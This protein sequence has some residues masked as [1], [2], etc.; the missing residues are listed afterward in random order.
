MANPG[1]IGTP[2][3]SS[4]ADDGE[5]TVAVARH[6]LDRAPK[7]RTTAES[8]EREADR[9][10]EAATDLAELGFVFFFFLSFVCYGKSGGI[11]WKWW[12]WW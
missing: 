5:E 2:T 9:P 6:H 10:R 4:S 11:R 12:F 7:V 8:S 1:E 3:T